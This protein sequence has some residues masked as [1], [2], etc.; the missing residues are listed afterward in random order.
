MKI[1]LAISGMDFGGAERVMSILAN[2][3]VKRGHAVTLITKNYPNSAYK[4]DERVNRINLPINRIAGSAALGFIKPI[5][6]CIKELAPDVIISFLSDNNALWAFGT[7]GLKRTLIVSERNDPHKVP[8][9]FIGRIIRN[10]AYHFADGYVFQTEDAKHYFGKRI[11]RKGI[12]IFNPLETDKIPKPC[13][14]NKQPRIV[15]VNRLEPQKKTENLI[16]AFAQ[17]AE[18]Y[19]EYQLDIY[20]K[21]TLYEHLTDVIFQMKMQ[22]RIHLCGSK[23][24]VLELIG[25]AEIFVLPSDFE[26]MP[27]ALMEAMALGLACISTDCPI[28]GPRSLIK[29]KINGYLIPVGDDKALYNAIKELIEDKSMTEMISKNSLQISNLVNVERIIDIWESYIY[30]IANRT[31]M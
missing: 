2:N 19:P 16:R 12:V 23:Q 17:I 22:D 29:D 7:W 15:A 30:Q 25:N 20:G 28:G 26:G 21:G 27:N 31:I 6:K 3:F 13:K 8:F 10:I 1:V 18:I 5:R 24:N 14:G 9:S 4:L 11:Q